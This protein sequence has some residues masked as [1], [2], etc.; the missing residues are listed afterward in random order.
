MRATAAVF[1][2]TIGLWMMATAQAEMTATAYQ[3]I[4]VRSG[5]GTQF[6]IV[7]QLAEGDAVPV[8]GRES[9]ATRWYHII[10]PDGQ[11]G[12]VSSFTVDLNGEPDGLPIIEPDGEIQ[13]TSVV[14]IIT[15]G[16][17]NVRSGPGINYDV[18]GQLDVGE[19]AP[20]LARNNR[21]NDW[22]YIEH[23]IVNGWVAYF[24]VDVIGDA[25]TLPIRVPDG[26][27]EELVAPTSLIRARYNIRV[28]ETPDSA[29]AIIGLVDF[30]SRVTPVARSEDGRWLYIAYENIEGWA[31]TE[32]FEIS[33]SY[34]STLP[35]FTPRSP[36]PTL[37]ATAE[38]TPEPASP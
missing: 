32:L 27:G 28:R 18:V 34:L 22:L 26:N 11:Q 16:R 17:V 37:E 25:G 2:I 8:N 20:A 7:G 13:A 19:E 24:T 12:W 23:E 1:L 9:E 15:Y 29:S 35:I 31:L 4:N 30:D 10:L 21:S 36:Q 6:E 38:I 14:R 5:P 33:E 3:T